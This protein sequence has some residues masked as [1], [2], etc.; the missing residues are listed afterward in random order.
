[1]L[2]LVVANERHDLEERFVENTKEA[3]ENIKSLREIENAIL[4][5]L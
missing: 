3:F 2:S 5:Q 1:M 4:E